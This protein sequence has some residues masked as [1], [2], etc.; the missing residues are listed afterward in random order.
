ML[1][2]VFRPCW[3]PKAPSCFL[4]HTCPWVLCLFPSGLCHLFVS[5]AL[6]VTLGFFPQVLFRASRL[7][8]Y[9]RLGPLPGLMGQLTKGS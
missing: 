3:A 1:R 6:F 9:P 7:V 8:D 4:V 5:G 2:C